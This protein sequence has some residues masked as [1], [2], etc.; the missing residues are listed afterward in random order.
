MAPSPNIR[1][2]KFYY[3]VLGLVLVAVRGLSMGWRRCLGKAAMSCVFSIA[4]FLRNFVKSFGFFEYHVIPAHTYC[5][6][7]L[8]RLESAFWGCKY[9]WRGLEKPPKPALNP[10]PQAKTQHRK[11]TP[12]PTPGIQHD[13]SLL[14][15]RGASGIRTPNSPIP[16]STLYNR[17]TI[18]PYSPKTFV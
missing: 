3:S 10:K 7:R 16:F 14:K 15:S 6:V 9:T 11:I 8:R 4:E 17:V 12:K 1:A 18:Q 13:L 5:S 2:G